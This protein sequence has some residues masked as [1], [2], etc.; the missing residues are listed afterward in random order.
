MALSAEFPFESKFVLVRGS[1]MHYID[2]GES[3]GDTPVYLFIHG[4]PTS[5]YLWRNVIPPIVKHARCIAFDLIGFGKS[6]RPDMGYKFLDHYKYVEDFIKALEL[7]NIVIVGHDWGGALGFYY[8]MKH[9]DN[10]KGYTA[11]ETFAFTFKWDDFPDDFKMGFKLFRAPIIGKFMVMVMNVF[12]KKILPQAIHGELSVEAHEY[13]KAA[14]PTIASRFP[15]Y[16]WPNEIPIDDRKDETYHAIK[17]IENHFKDF[18]FPILLLTA[19][20]GGIVTPA[21]VAWFKRTAWSLTV[22]DLGAGIHYLQEDN[23]QGIA[24]GIIQWSRDKGFIT[25]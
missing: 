5:S 6:D 20:P 17:T 3:S 9:P 8:A 23:P 15:V 21:R 19:T 11:F 7:K 13:Y 2:E 12:I 25:M 14:F 24:D 4:N 10:V 18:K 22:M 1:K 16:V